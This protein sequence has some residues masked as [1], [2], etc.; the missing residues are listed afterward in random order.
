[1]AIHFNEPQSVA[2]DSGL[3][4]TYNFD[5]GITQTITVSE[6]AGDVSGHHPNWNA[7]IPV[8]PAASMLNIL[9]ATSTQGVWS[10][11]GGS[12]F[13]V[14][15]CQPEVINPSVVKTSI[16]LVGGVPEWTITITNPSTT[17]ASPPAGLKAA[18]RRC[19]SGRYRQSPLA[20]W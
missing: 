12:S 10:G 19:S 13:S 3:V 18:G 16:G 15:S 17:T 7:L 20:A 1:M 2:P 9:S 4:V 11:N 8:P 14:A 5:G 6:D